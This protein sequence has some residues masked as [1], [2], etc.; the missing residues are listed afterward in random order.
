MSK[1]IPSVKI[2]GD[3]VVLYLATNPCSEHLCTQLCLL[4]GLRPRYYTCHC[5]SGW[6]L[7]TDKRTCIKGTFFL[8]SFLFFLQCSLHQ[9]SQHLTILVYINHVEEYKDRFD[10]YSFCCVSDKMYVLSYSLAALCVTIVFLSSCVLL[11]YSR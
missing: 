7:D 11:F 8:Q 4:S 10:F 1:L 5:Q 3:R 6:K 2:E 9:C